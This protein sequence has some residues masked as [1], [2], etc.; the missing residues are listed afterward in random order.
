[1][2]K[3]LRAVSVDSKIINWAVRCHDADENC[4]K[5]MVARKCND[6]SLYRMKVRVFCL[7]HLGPFMFLFMTYQD[8]IFGK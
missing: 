1:M 5:S 4:R 8:L 2:G 7:L 3:G 6:Q